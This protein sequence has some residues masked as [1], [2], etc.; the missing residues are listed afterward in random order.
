MFASQA[1]CPGREPFQW[2]DHKPLV[3]LDKDELDPCA[4]RLACL[5]ARWTARRGDAEGSDTIDPARVQSLIEAARLSL[6]TA[7]AIKGDHTK[8]R[9]AIDQASSHLV[10]LVDD[11]KGTLDQL[12]AEICAAVA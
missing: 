1:A 10:G 3:V 5:W 6:R 12:E 7:T 2:F 8:A 11:L 4:L 9:T